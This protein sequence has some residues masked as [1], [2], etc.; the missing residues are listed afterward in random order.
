VPDVAA[1]PTIFDLLAGRDPVLERAIA[2]LT[3]P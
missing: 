2:L 3:R 1:E